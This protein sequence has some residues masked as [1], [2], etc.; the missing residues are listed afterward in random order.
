MTRFET[1]I[2]EALNNPAQKE[3]FTPTTVWHDV[4]QAGRVA[5]RVMAM[6]QGRL[7]KIET[8]SEV[9]NAEVVVKNLPSGKW[10]DL[11]FTKD[12]RV[13]ANFPLT[14]EGA[15]TIL[16]ASKRWRRDR[17]LRIFRRVSQ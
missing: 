7:E 8:A 9:I 3:R 2:A 6:S 16:S 17:Q 1:G 4:A 5:D 10:A 11:L 13:C 14:A 12:A 15:Y